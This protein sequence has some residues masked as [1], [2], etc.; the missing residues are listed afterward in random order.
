M[1]G[2]SSNTISST[3]EQYDNENI[4][5]ALMVNKQIVM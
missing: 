1:P 4:K 5:S 3:I 2:N